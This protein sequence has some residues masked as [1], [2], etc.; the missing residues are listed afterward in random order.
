MTSE[1]RDAQL[2]VTEVGSMGPRN[3]LD[4]MVTGALERAN[5]RAGAYTIVMLS[6]AVRHKFRGTCLYQ[7]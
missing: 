4:D 6:T 3:P 2:H 1:D 7:S 5:Q